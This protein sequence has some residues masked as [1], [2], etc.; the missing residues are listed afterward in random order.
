M[1]IV[2]LDAYSLG[3]A[4]LA[5][6][7]S[8]G[9]CTCYE[10][11]APADTAARCAGADV[12]VTN[13]VRITRDIMTQL[14]QLR[15]I[16]VA[17]TGTNNIDMEAAADL[18]IAVKNVPG[19]STYSVVET[20]VA[21]ALGLWR[22]T[23]YYDDF[24][25]SG[26][27]SASGRVFHLDRPVHELRGKC[28]GIIGMGQIG[29]AVAQVAEALGT[30]VCYYS[31]SGGNLAAGYPCLP[32]D[33][34]M[35]MADIVSVHAPL[36]DRTAGL[37]DE[38]VLRLVRP[39]AVIVNVARGGIVD[40]VAVA[41]ALNEGRLAGYAADVFPEEPLPATSPLFSVTDRTRLMLTP[42]YAWA[43][44]EARER[45][46]HVMA[47]HIRQLKKEMESCRTNRREK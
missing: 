20:T 35:Q 47:E 40:E 31:T 4:D 25:K 10:E 24:V 39:S 28:W 43:S 26:A 36:N 3:D 38:A 33:R 16:C 8:L 14:P 11:T 6:V 23:A 41:R 7:T 27:Y 9:D 46:V 42:H 15:L 44:A 12:V 29:R 22:Q 21:M 17:A 19:Y 30:T 32:L 13:K 37:V 45:L 2:L 5:P 1:R 18:G 34:L